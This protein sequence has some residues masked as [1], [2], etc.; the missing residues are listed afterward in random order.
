M[1][2]NLSRLLILA[3]ASNIMVEVNKIKRSA[4]DGESDHKGHVG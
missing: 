2:L 1:S 3:L 4:G